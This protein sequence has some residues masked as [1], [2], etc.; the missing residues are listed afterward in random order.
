MQDASADWDRDDGGGSLFAK[1]PD[2]EVSGTTP[3]G[4]YYYLIFR[5]K[6]EHHL[7]VVNTSQF[8]LMTRAWVHQER[9]LSPRVLHFGYYELAFE[10]STETY[11]L[12][13]TGKPNKKRVKKATFF[14]A[15]MWRSLVTGYSALHLAKPND[16]FPALSGVART[17]AEKRKSE[18]LADLFKDS[19][20]D[21]LLWTA[22]TWKK[23]R[24]S[25]WRA[26]SWSW[27][28][29]K[30]SITYRDELIASIEHCTCTLDGL[31][32]FGK[33]KSAPLRITSQILPARLI[34]EADPDTYQRPTYR[35]HIH[36]GA[37]G[38]RIWPDYDLSQAGPYQ[39]LSGTEVH[40]LRMIRHIEDNLDVSLVIRAVRTGPGAVFERIG[41][42]ELDSHTPQIDLLQSEIR[43][44]FL[45]TLNQAQ[46]RTVDIE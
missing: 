28:S 36:D 24:L 43:D 2:F 19:L 21:D 14:I 18:Y 7:S 3:E 44:R 16:C 39:V 5:E 37:V 34:R 27:A 26:P 42:L 45:T 9:M 41:I 10:C 15:R 12:T 35:V 4:E 8:P 6:I 11:S 23:P 17:F 1:T 29:T 25:E 22:V 20:I 32:T 33:I 38:P 31:D 30:S 46:V 40:C 13:T